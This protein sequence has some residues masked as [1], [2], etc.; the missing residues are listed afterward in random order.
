MYKSDA[1]TVALLRHTIETL[2]DDALVLIDV[3]NIGRA[4][5]YADYRMDGALVIE[6]AVEGVEDDPE[7]EDRA[8]AERDARRDG[9][10]VR[11]KE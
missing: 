4:V 1:L 7:D 5:S 10:C 2:P 6:A 11:L 3:E 9:V 8:D